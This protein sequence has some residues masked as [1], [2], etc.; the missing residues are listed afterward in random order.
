MFT[1]TIPLAIQVSGPKV[2]N[3]GIF[4][5]NIIKSRRKNCQNNL[6]FSRPNYYILTSSGPNIPNDLPLLAFTVTT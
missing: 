2:Q 5:T 3:F 1:K 4:Q 6:V